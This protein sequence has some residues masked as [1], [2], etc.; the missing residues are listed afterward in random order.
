METF[1]FLVSLGHLN[2]NNRSPHVSLENV[3]SLFHTSRRSAKIAWCQFLAIC[4]SLI[5]QIFRWSWLSTTWHCFP[6]LL[7]LKSRWLKSKPSLGK[8]WQR[9]M[10]HPLAYRKCKLL[11][12]WEPTDVSGEGPMQYIEPRHGECHRHEGDGGKEMWDPQGDSK[13]GGRIREIFS[14]RLRGFASWKI[15]PTKAK[16]CL[17][18]ISSFLLLL[19]GKAGLTVVFSEWYFSW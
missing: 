3:F 15:T 19:W 1:G 17:R 8:G 10:R 12:A 13:E 11:Q 18:C 5:Q 2:Y 6:W 4:R 14:E 16:N 9:H 7:S